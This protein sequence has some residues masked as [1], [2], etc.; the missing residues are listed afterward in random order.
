MSE[1]LRRLK[2][3]GLMYARAPDWWD[4]GNNEGPRAYMTIL[5]I[6]ALREFTFISAF[7]HKPRSEFKHCDDIAL[8]MSGSLR[9]R[10]WDEQAGYLMNFNGTKLDPHM[11]MG[12]LLAGVFGS[13]DTA[14]AGRLVRTAAKQLF[15]EGLGIRAVMPPDF[16]TDS[17]KAYFHFAGNE[18]GDPYRYINGGVWPH[19]NAW[20]AMAL[21]AT[22]RIDDAYAFYR[23][24]MTLDG[25]ARSPM[26]QP[27][28]YEYR[29]SNPASPRYGEIDKPS[30]LWAAG[31]SLLAGYRVLGIQENEWNIAF[32]G[33]LPAAVDT[34]RCT[35][36]F[37]GRKH[38]R[39][40]GKGN[41][42]RSF[43]ADGKEI[44]SLVI[45]LDAQDTRNWTVTL[46]NPQQPYLA[47]INAQLRSANYDAGK[48]T[49]R[50]IVLS[51]QGHHGNATVRVPARIRKV[52][53]DGK[54]VK[55]FTIGQ[56]PEGGLS[57]MLRFTGTEGAQKI[58]I[59]L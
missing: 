29:Y 4:I 20:Y 39:I 2:D 51:Y 53:V 28:F 40:L 22:G 45:P 35:L 6:R 31:F 10:L 49:L 41:G 55:S 14:R 44:P 24:T 46:G 5:V 3:D 56:D 19:N 48:R 54:E 47:E 50:L 57:L 42:L 34:T 58:T 11:Y 37:W 36:E 16:H 7:L 8:R 43:T 52:S 38:I 25:I 23:S 9:R 27:A 30:F 26:G 13:L 18:A 12:S 32:S 1:S 15:A 21:S 59:T 17:L 33:A